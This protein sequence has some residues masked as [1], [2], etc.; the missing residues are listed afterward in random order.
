MT[1]R[2]HQIRAHL[3]FIGHPVV[4]DKIYIDLAIFQRYVTNGLDAEMLER[5]KLPRL[6]LH[7][8]WIALKH[9][10]TE[11]EVEYRSALP[12]FFKEM[13]K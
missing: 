2:T 6:A 11:A 8:S 12:N 9:P 13:L 4:G 7:A 1:G 10:K 3:S 5:L